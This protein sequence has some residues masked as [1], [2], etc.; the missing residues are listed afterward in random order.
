[1]Y[2]PPCGPDQMRI[3]I[4]FPVPQPWAAEIAEARIRYGDEYGLMIPPHITIIG[5]TAVD[6]VEIP[7]LIVQLDNICDQTPAFDLRLDGTDTF[8]PLSPVVY[9]K[10]T[11]GFD[12]CVALQAALQRGPLV[13]PARFEYHPHVTLAH[14]VPPEQLDIAQHEFEN[15]SARF[16]VDALWLYRNDPDGVWRKDFKF[17]LRG[18]KKAA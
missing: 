2:I 16:H 6:R 9:L 11:D 10:V 13:S 18:K 14:D 15:L 1:M 3:G 8:R 12:D 5:P 7:A 4:S 17:A